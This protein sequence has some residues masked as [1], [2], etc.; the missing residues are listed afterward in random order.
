M[1]AVEQLAE[2]EAGQTRTLRVSRWK[3]GDT[4]PHYEEFTVS[5]DERTALVE[6]LRQ[7]RLREDPSLMIRHSCLHGS[8]GTCGVRV[9]G[10]EVLGCL[11]QVADLPPGPV[12]V[13]PLENAPLLGDLVVDMAPAYRRIEPAG[14]FPVRPTD[15]VS[16]PAPGV[17][18]LTQFQ[19][20]LECGLCASACPVSSVDPGF[21]PAALWA[22]AAAVEQRGANLSE[23]DALW[24]CTTCANCLRVCP[25]G[26]DMTQ[27]MPAIREVAVGDGRVPA[28]LQ[29]VFEKSFRYGNCLGENPRRRHAWT[30]DAGVDVRV[31][32]NDPAPVDVLFYVEDYWSYHPRGQTAAR[33]FARILSTLGVDFGILGPEEKTLGDSQRLAGEKGLFEALMDD[34]VATLGRYQFNRIVT[35]DPHGFNALVKEYPKRGHQY[36]VLHYTQ[37]LAPLVDRIDWKKR[38]DVTVTFHDP[39]YLGRHNGEYDAPRRLLQAIP[40]VR[41]VEMGR[42]RENGYCCG[43]G[44]GGM[45]LDSLTKD[46]MS[47][48]LS[49]RRVREAAATGADVLAVCCPYEVSLFEDAAK[50]TG[51]DHLAVRDIVELIDEAMG[52]GAGA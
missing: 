7:I 16:R 23:D 24:L 47:E 41:L 30:R 44:G 36:Q 19:D 2:T 42:C 14:L 4:L 45:W 6:A 29:D 40:G 51:N 3:P 22:A 37:F 18:Q 27:V 26:I 1:S 35:P 38:L 32:P 31:L 25:E 13:E 34:V 39:C 8:C 46:Y 9:N 28:E 11:T 21:F 52:N 33:A 49:E 10:R 20:C 43:G 15:G 5:Y 12:T 50:S 17:K 48:R